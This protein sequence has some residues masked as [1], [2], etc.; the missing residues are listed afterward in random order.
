[1]MSEILKTEDDCQEDDAKENNFSNAVF[2]PFKQKSAR[3][4]LGVFATPTAY[5]QGLL[6]D[7]GSVYKQK[8]RSVFSKSVN[9]RNV[10]KSTEGHLSGDVI[11]SEAL[12]NESKET[13]HTTNDS[14]SFNQSISD[15][16]KQT[17]LETQDNL[18]NVI[19]LGKT[20]EIVDNDIYDV[21]DNIEG[22][23]SFEKK[24]DSSVQSVDKFS[25]V[26]VENK[27]TGQIFNLSKQ[28]EF[29]EMQ[30]KFNVND[31][32][33]LENTKE[34]VK[35]SN[36]VEDSFGK[37]DESSVQSFEFSEVFVESKETAQ[38][39]SI[40]N[41]S[42]QTESYEIQDKFNDVVALEN[43]KEIVKDSNDVEDSFREKNESSVQ[44]VD[45]VFFNENE[46]TGQKADFPDTNDNL[47]QSISNLSNQAE[48]QDVTTLEKSTEIVN[49]GNN[50]KDNETKDESSQN[51]VDS[52]LFSLSSSSDINENVECNTNDILP[53][54]KQT[55]PY[56]QDDICSLSRDL[57]DSK[58]EDNSQ[59]L[60]KDLSLNLPECK[61]IKHD[62]ESE[63]DNF[64][65]I[66]QKEKLDKFPASSVVMCT[67]F[68]D[69][70]PHISQEVKLDNELNTNPDKLPGPESNNDL[71][72]SLTTSNCDILSTQEL[73]MTDD[74]DHEILQLFQ[75]TDLFNEKPE[76]KKRK[77]ASKRARR[78]SVR[79]QLRAINLQS[80]DN[81]ML[82]KLEQ[83]HELDP[84]TEGNSLSKN[85]DTCKRQTSSDFPSVEKESLP[86]PPLN[87]NEELI[88]LVDD[89]NDDKL[90]PPKKKVGRPKGSRN[91][92]RRNV[93]IKK[94]V[95][96]IQNS[97]VEFNFD[98]KVLMDPFSQGT[99]LP[100]DNPVESQTSVDD[101][102]NFDG[103]DDFDIFKEIVEPGPKE[104]RTKRREQEDGRKRERRR[105]A[106]IAG[107][108]A[109]DTLLSLNKSDKDANSDSS[110]RKIRKIK[111]TSFGKP[112]IMLNMFGSM[113]DDDSFESMEQ[114]TE[115]YEQ[116]EF[117]TPEPP[118][119]QEIITNSISCEPL[120]PESLH[121]VEVKKDLLDICEE[122]CP[123]E[124]PISEDVFI[125]EIESTNLQTDL[126]CNELVNNTEPNVSLAEPVTACDV[127]TTNDLL[128]PDD[129]SQVQPIKRQSSRRKQVIHPVLKPKKKKESVEIPMT[130]LDIEQMYINRGYCCKLTKPCLLET[131]FEAEKNEDLVI[132]FGKRKINRKM[133]FQ[134]PWLPRKRNTKKKGKRLIG[135]T[136][137]FKI[138]DEILVERLNN[139][140]SDLNSFD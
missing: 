57:S 130:S 83:I 41:F 15:L 46:E 31:I 127:A 85:N 53:L 68:I 26:F 71:P 33:A 8:G 55:T 106:R 101:D 88:H 115:N 9:V 67:E 86:Q 48:K 90:N 131:I 22:N 78:K 84:V 4:N 114:E 25:E 134:S 92:K 95:N 121:S 100:S 11:C 66:L 60:S 38:N 112:L 36:D 47:S 108:P 72:E 64:T 43:T 56:V 120:S 40:S 59:V 119:P 99:C 12:V 39:E 63:C 109:I 129:T 19:A 28:T 51:T 7:F 79:L 80:Q 137:N 96:T 104:K 44:S 117:A 135:K 89:I 14:N 91:K 13:I 37:K 139:I 93:T 105:S 75:D 54:V 124:T 52:G 103:L 58:T 74:I 110:M 18:I 113:Q 82:D 29:Y 17:D 136:R 87:T 122:S 35:D 62:L 98:S 94:K 23:H 70:T 21:K 128:M 20:K 69:S 132:K 32:V 10:N 5:Y 2:T 3:R 107:I 76:K 73:K 81:C 30:D 45:E 97:S 126:L 138:S 65:C 42:K 125:C 77:D 27:K 24:E 116:I 118:T 1:M 16:S 133:T 61:N 140:L 34:I 49:D 123:S 50:C 6:T 102:D 111:R